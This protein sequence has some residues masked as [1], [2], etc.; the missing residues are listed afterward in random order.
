MDVSKVLFETNFGRDRYVG[1]F[2]IEEEGDGEVGIVRF[3]VE[4]EDF[5]EDEFF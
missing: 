2:G 3:V 5:V 4:K 1:E